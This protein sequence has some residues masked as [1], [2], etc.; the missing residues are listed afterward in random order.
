MKFER[1]IRILEKAVAQNDY[2]MAR[3]VIELNIEKFNQPSIRNQLTLDAVTLINC[4]TSFNEK[5]QKNVFS[6]ETQ[7]IVQH[8]NKLAQTGS[9]V[10]LKRYCSLQSSLLTDP[11]IYEQLSN[12]VKILIPQHQ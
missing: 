9:F 4:V 6:R 5:D 1:E 8:I 10:T 11:K 7:L 3:R 2:V 12:D